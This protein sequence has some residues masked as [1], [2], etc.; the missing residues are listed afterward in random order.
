MLGYS[1]NNALVT[2]TYNKC[3]IWSRWSK[4]YTHKGSATR[5]AF[6]CHYVIILS[7]NIYC[8]MIRCSV[9][10]CCNIMPFIIFGPNW[11]QHLSSGIFQSY[12]L[13]W[14]GITCAWLTWIHLILK[15]NNWRF[16]IS[17]Y[18][19]FSVISQSFRE[20]L[21]ACQETLLTICRDFSHPPF[22]WR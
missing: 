10:G 1:S 6:P 14:Y 20:H 17:L 9:S 15:P 12:D 21:F 16:C 2:C 8:I 7:K 11:H 5:K 13:P 3:I 18:I 4:D 19:S 22:Y